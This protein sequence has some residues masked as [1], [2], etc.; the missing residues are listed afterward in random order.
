VRQETVGNENMTASRR[1]VQHRAGCSATLPRINRRQFEAL[2]PVTRCGAC[3]RSSLCGREDRTRHRRN[4]NMET[5]GQALAVRPAAELVPRLMNKEWVP[6]A[7]CS[8]SLCA[9]ASQIVGRACSPPFDECRTGHDR[10][11]S[12]VRLRRI[13][14]GRSGE[15]SAGIARAALGR[16]TTGRLWEVVIRNRHRSA[17]R[18]KAI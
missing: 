8:T 1:Y 14:L 13:R 6:P 12:V 2:C 3:R 9:G 16:R 18:D 4:C 11:V 10:N 7:R 17:R 15:P 5:R